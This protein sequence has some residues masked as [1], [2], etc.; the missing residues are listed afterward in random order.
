MSESE[1]LSPEEAIYLLQLKLGRIP[2]EVPEETINSLIN[3]G[4]IYTSDVSRGF[5]L[6]QRAKHRI[7]NHVLKERKLPDYISRFSFPEAF[8]KF[9]STAS[10]PAVNALCISLVSNNRLVGVNKIT[11]KR[12][13]NLVDKELTRQNQSIK[14]KEDNGSK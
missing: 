14:I 12:M 3:K 13:K 4:Y 9:F 7:G 1:D 10:L 11:L 2:T 5:R 6:T 8:D